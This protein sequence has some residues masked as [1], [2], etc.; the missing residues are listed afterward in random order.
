MEIIEPKVQLIRHNND[1]YS[2]IAKIARICYAS[3]NANNCE[4]F[5]NR[6]IQEGHLSI[7]RHYPAYYKIPINADTE[8][9]LHDSVFKKGCDFE[10]IDVGNYTYISAN[11]Q[12]AHE[13][14]GE[15]VEKYRV[16]AIEAAND[17]VF[18]NA[19]LLRYTFV[20]TTGIDIS[21]ELNRKSPN[22]IIEQSTRYVDFNKKLG[23]RFKRCHWMNNLNVIQKFIVKIIC[24]L[25]EWFYKISRSKFG[26]NLKPED[27]RWCLLLDSAT[28]VAYTYT[29]RDWFHILNARL[30]DKTGVSHPDM[31]VIANEIKTILEDEGYGVEHICKQL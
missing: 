25:D 3:T 23:I 13:C 27:A 11:E 6:R 18:L 21:R 19:L 4:D 26:L 16:D 10:I 7:L 9:I 17:R 5:V 20:I 22:N 29:A 14:F 31:K 8:D 15:R 12:V 1:K 30:F 2:H 24:K 28:K